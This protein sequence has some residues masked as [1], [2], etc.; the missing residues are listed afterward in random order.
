MIIWLA[1]YPKSGN[2]WLRVFLHA[3]LFTEKGHVNFENL[4]NISQYPL[5]SHFKGLIKKPLTNTPK[6]NLN[7]KL[8]Y[9]NLNEDALDT[10]FYDA[11]E[12]LIGSVF[13][14]KQWQPN[15]FRKYSVG[16]KFD[17]N[18][19]FLKGTFR[20]DFDLK[21]SKKIRTKVSMGY[22]SFL[23][24]KKIPKQFKNYLFGSVD[25]N[26]EQLVFNRTQ[27]NNDLK[28]LEK[29]YYGDGMRGVDVENYGLSNKQSRWL[30][31]I[32]QELPVLP[33]KLFFDVS[34]G[35]D[36]KENYYS[37]FGMVL[38]PFIVP[39]FQ[40]WETENTSPQDIQW[41]LERIRFR[42]NLDIRL[43]N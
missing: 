28:I 26:F 20:T 37:A 40:S 25:P 3:I 4:N 33:G 1:S 19:E 43:G 12:Y 16:T 8:F 18:H 31:K 32:D 6:I 24:S 35:D 21:I 30:I 42:L 5:R 36:L 11:G 14:N 9:H 17:F 34:G 10:N 29:M 13:L 23:I 38:G 2:T 7:L 39:L 22:H 41:I 27:E 15:I